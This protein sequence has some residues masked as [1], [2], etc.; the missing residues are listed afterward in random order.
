MGNS[1]SEYSQE[2][3]VE[4]MEK[5]TGITSEIS[6]RI[7]YNQ[8]KMEGWLEGLKKG[9]RTGLLVGLVTGILVTSSVFI[10]INKYKNMQSEE[11][12]NRVHSSTSILE[13][14][15]K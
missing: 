9:T 15:L 10:G 8:G 6:H 13:G 11:N 3:L 1:L 12:N 7:G 5:Y 4:G 2:E 14:E